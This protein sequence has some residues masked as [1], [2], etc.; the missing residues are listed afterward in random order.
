MRDLAL[1]ELPMLTLVVNRLE[2]D[3][4][5]IR[6]E[7]MSCPLLWRCRASPAS[8]PAVGVVVLV[9]H[10]ADQSLLNQSAPRSHKFLPLVLGLLELRFLG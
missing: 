9:H 5:L 1:P 4:G 2:S 3:E 10:R 8:P 7:M 6:V